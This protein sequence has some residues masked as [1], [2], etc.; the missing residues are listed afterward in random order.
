MQYR[1]LG[2]RGLEVS[3]VGFG[4]MTLSPGI[5]A[6]VTEADAAAALVAALDAGV[7]F[8][9]TADIYGAGHS[10]TLIGRV[11]GGRRDHVVLASKFGG[12]TDAEGRLL[13]GMGRASYLRKALDASLTRLNTDHLDLYYLHRLDVT[14]PVEETVGALG[15][16]VEEGK[17]N[18]IGLSEVSASTIRRA[19]AVHP[20][21]AIQTEYSLFS[22]GPEDGVLPACRE[23]GI[24]F[25]AYSP[26]G[27]GLL[28]GGVRAAGDLAENDWRR[29]NP[30]FQGP[31]LEHNVS[32]AD[33]VET[34]AA[35][36]EVT[37]AQL[38]LAWLIQRGVV[39]IPGT[40]R[41]SNVLANAAAA[42]LALDPAVF[43][44]LESL[45]PRDAV[46]GGQADDSYL[47]A[48]DV[49]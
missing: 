13:P 21:T 48:I 45:V 11:L 31:N 42:D 1:S 10:E 16:L 2:R 30:R 4:A 43:D 29:T 28:G 37:G 20:I 44:R 15:E 25:V 34:V 24:G 23:L 49:T 35:E 40:R 14:T 7:T 19:D 39:P 47:A 46:A 26:L 8:I 32:V 22:R 41:A 9:D 18:H 38:A 27:R 17:I 36:L 33:A 5:Y 12:D 6:G 3:A